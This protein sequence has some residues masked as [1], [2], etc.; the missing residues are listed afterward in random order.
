M[1]T[2]TMLGMF[3]VGDHV[4]ENIAVNNSKLDYRA[5]SEGKMYYDIEY[6]TMGGDVKITGLDGF[7]KDPIIMQFIGLRDK[8]EKKIYAG[9]AVKSWVSLGV[10]E[11]SH[12]VWGINWD[13]YNVGKNT[14]GGNGRTQ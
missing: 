12:G 6:I 11:F 13:Y 14:M 7:L 10:V 4:K 8:C 9:D 1:E 3:T 2:G 5:F